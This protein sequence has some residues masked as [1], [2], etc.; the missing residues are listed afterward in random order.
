MLTFTAAQ[1]VFS[2]GDTSTGGQPGERPPVLIGSIFFSGHRIVSDPIKGVFDE[3]RARDLL[4]AEAELAEAY[5]LKRMIDVVG[6]T[7]EALV[8]YIEFV[9]AHTEDPIL[10]DSSFTEVRLKACR[11]FKGTEVWPRLVYNSIDEHHTE[12]DWEELAELGP[13]AAVVLAFSSRALQPAAVLRL[14][15]GEDGRGGL[16]GR[17]QAIG[18]KKLLVDVGCLDVPGTARSALLIKEVKDKLGYP[19][20]CAPSNSFHTWQKSRFREEGE[21][22]AAGAA[23]YAVPLL[24]G[25][26][27]IFYGPIRHAR[28]VYPACAAASAVVAYGARQGGVRPMKNHPLYKIF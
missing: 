6:D 11:H 21:M 19:A 18:I 14:L 13:E 26:D 22:V 12:K 10:V 7:E 23:V 5:G 9:A 24:W 4:T 20:G 25:A 17:A 15:A 27:F 8:R 3:A 16:L 2:W 28:W 1:K